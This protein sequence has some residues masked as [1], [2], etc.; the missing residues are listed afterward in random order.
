V[1]A[2]AALRAAPRPTTA[3]R[4]AAQLR[5]APHRLPPESIELAYELQRRLRSQE[6]PSGGNRWLHH[7]WLAIFERMLDELERNEALPPPGFTYVCMGAGVRN[8]YAFSFLMVLAGAERVWIVEPEGLDELPAWKRFWGLQELALRVLVGD[9]GSTR[10]L[11]GDERANAFVDVRELFFG[12]PSRAL[13]N[14]VATC[15][16]PIEDAPIPDS[17]VHLLSSRSVLEH[18]LDVDRCFDALARVLR[19]GG[20]MYHE[21][22]L[23]SHTGADTFAFYRD[24]R[25]R[26]RGLNELRLSDYLREFERRGFECRL[27][28]SRTTEPPDRTTLQPRFARYDTTDLATAEARL[29]AIRR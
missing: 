20:V 14:T 7:R 15:S 5:R 18:V 19:P 9:V 3:S 29:I 10:F 26:S 12:A 11:D 8:P 24:L 2:R 25:A 17:S 13:R 23:T 16:A 28:A 6:D 1:R 27:L 22:D 21:I 4:V